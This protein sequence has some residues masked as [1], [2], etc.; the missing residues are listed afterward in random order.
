MMRSSVRVQRGLPNGR[1]ARP[2]VVGCATLLL[3]LVG[4]AGAP[5]RDAGGETVPPVSSGAS[6]TPDAGSVDEPLDECPVDA[7]TVS[8]W[9]GTPMTALVDDSRPTAFV[10]ETVGEQTSYLCG[11]RAND[12][13]GSNDATGID[14][15]F[16]VG[17]SSASQ[18]AA[19]GS[20][21]PSDSHPA[22]DWV[23]GVDAW[24][25]T[26]ERSGDLVQEKSVQV[27]TDWVT[28]SVVVV[29][30]ANPTTLDVAQERVSRAVD[31]VLSALGG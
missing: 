17:A 5:A 22:A 26:D 6:V 7:A 19:I 28:L 2:A 15:S 8:E 29:A 11:F 14:L 18:W 23:D 31:G 21:Y 27:H 16:T 4:C 30:Y 3:T 24:E 9:F 12:G 1:L 20:Q 13:T 10:V 25:G